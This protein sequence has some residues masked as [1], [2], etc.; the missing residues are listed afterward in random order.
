[1]NTIPLLLFAF[2]SI[3]LAN[4]QPSR[5]HIKNSFNDGGCNTVGKM[6][7]CGV[8]TTWKANI[9]WATDGEVGQGKGMCIISPDAAVNMGLC[10]VG[11]TWVTTE[12]WET[13]QG[14][15]QG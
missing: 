8:G 3:C 10:G 4:D 14:H 1:M 13:G 9:Q 6:G 5:F 15:G 7:L 2:F 11:T 12:P